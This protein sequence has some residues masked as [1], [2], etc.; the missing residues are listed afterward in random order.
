VTE[1]TKNTLSLIFAFA[2]FSFAIWLGWD[3]VKDRFRRWDQATLEKLIQEVKAQDYVAK[4]RY[5]RDRDALIGFALIAAITCLEAFT[6]TGM[7]P[8]RKPVLVAATVMLQMWSGYVA[9][10]FFLSAISQNKRATKLYVQV[11]LKKLEKMYEKYKAAAA[12]S[13]PSPASDDAR[14]LVFI[15]GPL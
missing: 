13:S 15:R 7:Y 11:R 1:S 4:H 8:I 3:T 10:L 14:A 12:A 9:F 2:S 6:F 5:L